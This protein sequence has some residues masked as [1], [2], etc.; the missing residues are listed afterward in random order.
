MAELAGS[1]RRVGRTSLGTM[2]RIRTMTICFQGRHSLLLAI[3]LGLERFWG[4]RTQ[5]YFSSGL[6]SGALWHQL[7]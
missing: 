6:S 3:I 1:E 5:L 7:P 4:G 2:L